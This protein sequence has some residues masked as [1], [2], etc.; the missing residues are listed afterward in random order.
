MDRDGISKLLSVPSSGLQFP[1][2]VW[3]WIVWLVWLLFHVNKRNHSLHS[4][5]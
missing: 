3:W 1:G 5:R 2:V 4:F